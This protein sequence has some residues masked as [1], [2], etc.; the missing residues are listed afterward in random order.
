MFL[1]GVAILNIYYSVEVRVTSN[2]ECIW[3]PKKVSKDSVA[4]FFEMVKF[5]GVTWNAGIRNGDQLIEIGGKTIYNA[6]QATK[7]FN[8]YKLE[9]TLV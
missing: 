3:A 1:I 2:D 9:N 4:H 8:N 6:M 7:I 5:K